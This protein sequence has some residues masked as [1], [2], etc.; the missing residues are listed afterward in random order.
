ML[1]LERQLL[2]DHVKMQSRLAQFVAT[3]VINYILGRGMA[4]ENVVCVSLTIH[5][6]GTVAVLHNGQPWQH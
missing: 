6:N 3:A 2:G 5:F 4:M 1:V